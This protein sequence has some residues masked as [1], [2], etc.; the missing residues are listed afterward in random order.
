MSNT[1]KYELVVQH[2]GKDVAELL[3]KEGAAAMNALPDNAKEIL[4]AIESG[5]I[6]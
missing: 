3:S 6:T 2:F 4:D 5:G 1:R